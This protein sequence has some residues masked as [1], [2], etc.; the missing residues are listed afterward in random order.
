MCVCLAGLSLTC[1]LH[2]SCQRKDRQHKMKTKLRLQCPLHLAK[3]LHNRNQLHRLKSSALILNMSAG[4]MEGRGE[5]ARQMKVVTSQR[6]ALRAN[7][8]RRCDMMT[9]NPCDGNSAESNHCDQGTPCADN[10]VEIVEIPVT[11]RMELFTG[12]IFNLQRG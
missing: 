7:I 4:K 11:A 3:L 10:L 5:L 2:Y 6:R 1:W 9:A 8:L 12:Q